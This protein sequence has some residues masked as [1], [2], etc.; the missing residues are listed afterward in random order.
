MIQE[1][2]AILDGIMV[3]VA[4]AAEYLVANQRSLNL[5]LVF[6]L[7]CLA[8]ISIAAYARTRP[9]DLPPQR[10]AE[11]RAANSPR[12]ADPRLVD[13]APDR[14]PV[15]P[16]LQ[17]TPT[18]QPNPLS[19]VGH[20]LSRLEE[21]YLQL[22]REVAHID[23]TGRDLRHEIEALAMRLADLR[24]ALDQSEIVDTPVAASSV[25]QP[26]RDMVPGTALELVPVATQKEVIPVAELNRY[27]NMLDE[28]TKRVDDLQGMVEAQRRTLLAVGQVLSQLPDWRKFKASMSESVDQVVS[29][30]EARSRKSG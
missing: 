29:A 3:V 25:P 20:R 5:I 6:A 23:E 7:L 2:Y 15:T 8:L 12:P 30:F 9:D 11:R 21:S 19:D 10:V 4:S 26:G 16:V 27:I 13:V 18:P 24:Q 17:V 1:L 22:N 14:G 28:T